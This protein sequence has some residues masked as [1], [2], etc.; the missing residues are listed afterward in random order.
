[1][2]ISWNQYYKEMA[3]AVSKRSKDPSTKVGTIIVDQE[4][5]VLSTGYNGFPS[6]VKETEERWERPEKYKIVSHAESNAIVFARQNL[7]NATM[8]CT[9]EPC[10][11]CMKLI[12]ASGIKTVYYNEARADEYS[13]M[14]AREA[15]ITVRKNNG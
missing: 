11:E 15:K 9:L 6:G 13:R 8:Y 4:Y 10:N 1:M 5:R 12:I 7:T 2:K 3:D 14:M